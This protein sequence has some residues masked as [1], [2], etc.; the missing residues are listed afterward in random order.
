[1]F[2]FERSKKKENEPSLTRIVKIDPVTDETT[3]CFVEDSE[4]EVNI[5]L[6]DIRN[7]K[8]SIIKKESQE[9]VNI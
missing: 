8:Y 6:R 5:D 4:F 1:M 9:R 2:I 3:Q 7:P